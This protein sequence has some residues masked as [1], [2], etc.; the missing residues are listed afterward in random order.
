MVAVHNEIVNGDVPL[1]RWVVLYKFLVVFV[2]CTF[3][4]IRLHFALTTQCLLTL[5]SCL[6]MIECGL[7]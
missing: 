5:L 6:E 3:V 2:R 1:W 7:K 4:S